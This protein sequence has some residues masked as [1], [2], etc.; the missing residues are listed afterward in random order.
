[1]FDE[2]IETGILVSVQQLFITIARMTEARCFDLADETL[3][4]STRCVVCTV[5]SPLSNKQNKTK[6]TVDGHDVCNSLAPRRV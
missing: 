6:C 2:V 4:K 3:E 5:C 1:L